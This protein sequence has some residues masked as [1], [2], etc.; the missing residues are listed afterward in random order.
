VTGDEQIELAGLVGLAWERRANPEALRAAVAE[1][2]DWWDR[3]SVRAYERQLGSRA[4]ALQVLRET[5]PASGP[6]DRAA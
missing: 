3:R 2:T 4:A 5:T 1:I 6:R